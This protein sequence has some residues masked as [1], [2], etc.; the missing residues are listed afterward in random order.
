MKLVEVFQNRRM[1][2]N[3]NA[4]G[5]QVPHLAESVIS[6]HTW[7]CGRKSHVMCNSQ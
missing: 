3:A 1:F 6:Q 5:K 2:N 4:T 7:P